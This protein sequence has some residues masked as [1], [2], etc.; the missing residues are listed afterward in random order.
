L[1]ILILAQGTDPN[2]ISKPELHGLSFRNLTLRTYR[3][4][5][6]SREVNTGQTVRALVHLRY[7]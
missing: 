5:P 3:D 1:Y 7:S 4:N 6:Y 2:L